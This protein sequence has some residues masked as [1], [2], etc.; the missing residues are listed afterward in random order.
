MPIEKLENKQRQG[1]LLQDKLSKELSS[2]HKL[3]K[4][5][6]LINW[7]ELEEE[8]GGIVNV[9]ALGR[10]RKSLR[11]MLSLSML[12]AMYNFS[13]CLTS[14]TFEE[15]LYWQ[16]FCG[17]EY[18]DTKL[19][20]S[21][22]AIRRF[23]QELGEEGYNYILKELT[24][25][26][27][28]VGA[29]KKKDLD[30]GIIDTTVQIKN[31][32]HPHDAYLL[33]KARVELVK[34]ANNLGFKLNETYE[35]KYK[36]GL[37]NLWKYKDVSKS[38]KRTKTMKHM[39]ILVG[40]LIRRVER[41]IT[42]V[43]MLLAPDKEKLLEKIKKI[44]AQSFL[45][46]QSKEKYKKAGN[47]VIY[48]FHAEEVECIGKGKLNKPYEFGNK[49]GIAVSGRGNFILAVK[50]FQD[51]PYD[52]HTLAETV[53]QMEKNT[54]IEVKK[55][56]VDLGYRGSNYKKKGKIYTPY[57]KKSLSKE[58]KIMQ[59][60][61]SAIEPVIGHLKQY[62]RMGRNYLKGVIGDILN[63]LISAIGFNLR[64]L[65]NKIKLPT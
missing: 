35:K 36:K 29:Y 10:E 18:I 48:S 55:I 53:A 63:P 5:K 19:S 20:V 27:L 42:E 43:N 15:N 57:T 9:R 26:G 51:N 47:E 60:R 39:K 8:V 11:V 25:V 3:Y 58:D 4:L 59:K 64:G 38:K 28:R 30:S 16:Y 46:K 50:S 65:A 12:Q 22:S 17:Y 21:E 32:K 7:S 45:S 2:K 54:E 52:G 61:R 33:G 24:K 23:R 6:E 13:D 40:R 14:E 49:V 34:L 62:G 1:R 44:Y 37:I 56:F 31:I 41:K